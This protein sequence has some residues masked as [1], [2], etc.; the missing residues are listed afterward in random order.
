MIRD[1][2][3]LLAWLS[4]GSFTA[5]VAVLGMTMIARTGEATMQLMLTVMLSSVVAWYSC[6]RMR[7][8]KI[9]PK[10]NV[11]ED[12]KDRQLRR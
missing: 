2:L 4:I 12:A 5:L 10:L 1:I 3:I 8:P 11:L 7:L 6:G 9:K